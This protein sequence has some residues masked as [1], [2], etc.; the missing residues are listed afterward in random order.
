MRDMNSFFDI[1]TSGEGY[2]EVI[3]KETRQICTI[4][5]ASDVMIDLFCRQK[6]LLS[7][8]SLEKAQVRRIG[9]GGLH[10]GEERESFLNVPSLA[11]GTEEVLIFSS[12]AK[13]FFTR[14][15]RA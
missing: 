10:R 5:G 14:S 4:L 13:D 15:S 11:E 7:I 12:G 3:S 2:N 1:A 9:G 6:I 8:A